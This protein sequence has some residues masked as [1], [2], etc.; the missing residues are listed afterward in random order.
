M[1][2]DKHIARLYIDSFQDDL[3]VIRLE[4][5]RLRTWDFADEPSL[6]IEP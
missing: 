2:R 6:T 4:P 3:V 5:G 1:R